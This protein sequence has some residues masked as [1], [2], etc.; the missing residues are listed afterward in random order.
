M[1][2][3]TSHA[4]NWGAASSHPITGDAFNLPIS[5]LVSAKEAKVPPPRMASQCRA[6]IYAF[7]PA[8]GYRSGKRNI[9]T[10]PPTLTGY[11][12]WKDISKTI[13]TT[14]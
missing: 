1:A 8:E 7:D 14:E 4:S 10:T 12:V 2:Q 5:M 3:K 13:T 6:R 11:S 9:F